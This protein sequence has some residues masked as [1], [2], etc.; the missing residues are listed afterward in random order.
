MPR[1]CINRRA[2]ADESAYNRNVEPT[3]QPFTFESKP[4]NFSNVK[5]WKIFVN[6]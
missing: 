2:P 3:T 5:E 4:K 6:D 1:V